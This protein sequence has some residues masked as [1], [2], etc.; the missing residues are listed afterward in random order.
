MMSVK[1]Q[2]A[3]AIVQRAASLGSLRWAFRVA[4]AVALGILLFCLGAAGFLTLRL[5]SADFRHT[6]RGLVQESLEKKV[7][8]VRLGECLDLRLDGQLHLCDVQLWRVDRAALTLEDVTIVLDL[9]SWWRGE[10][11]VDSIAVNGV[12]ADL[13]GLRAWWQACTT[14]TG[15]WP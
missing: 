6:L 2:S 15:A 12:D 7:G 8:T 14:R 5:R 4:R 13:D 9:W 10:R 1:K 11:R 3:F